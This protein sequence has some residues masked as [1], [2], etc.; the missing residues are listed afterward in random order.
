MRFFALLTALSVLSG[1]AISCSSSPPS[2]ASASLDSG[3]MFGCQN[4][5]R[6]EAYT[7][8][9]QKAGMAGAFT[10]VL[11]SS[12]PA[13]PAKL[14]NTWILKVVDTSG[15]P[16]TGA[17]FP[18]LPEWSGWPIGVRPYMPD[19]GHSSTAWPTVT[20]NPDGTYTINTLYFMMPGLWQITI[21]VQSGMTTDSV[22]YS[23]CVAG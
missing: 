12:N 2:S 9:M 21:N 4:D 16:V 11:V 15:K 22:Q 14:T 1:S 7:A 20:P 19:H 5:S 6:A 23:F 10:F 13:P 8:N 3:A 18:P 17:S